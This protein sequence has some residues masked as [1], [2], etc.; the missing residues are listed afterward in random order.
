MSWADKM[1]DDDTAVRDA[2]WVSRS[3]SERASFHTFQPNMEVLL[4]FSP[5]MFPPRVRWVGAKSVDSVKSSVLSQ[6]PLANRDEA[7]VTV[8]PVERMAIQ[9]QP[10]PIVTNPPDPVKLT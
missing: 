3:A 5:Y 8:P 9:T 7:T 6:L 2:F 10:V 4:E 1:P